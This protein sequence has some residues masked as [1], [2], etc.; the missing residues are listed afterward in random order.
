MELIQYFTKHRIIRYLIG[1]STSAVVNLTVF[2][3]LYSTIGVHYILASVFAFIIAFFV[4]WAFH[5]FWTFKDNS[6]DNFHI[7][8]FYY[9]LNSLFGLGLNTAI[10]F[11]C[12]HYLSL[13]PI[14]GQ[15]IAGGLT[16][17]CTFFI[18]KHFIFR[19]KTKQSILQ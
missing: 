9:L 7:Q 6:M 5:K 16:A 17:C 15:I 11:I 8:G 1:G 12:V 2:F 18:S 10:L 14:I 13:L 3:V 19:N 4:S